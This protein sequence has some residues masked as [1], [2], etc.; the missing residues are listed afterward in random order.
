MSRI[1]IA[2][3]TFTIF[4]FLILLL[5]LISV[6]MVIKALPGL[7]NELDDFKKKID[8]VDTATEKI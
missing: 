7:K 6:I 8:K 2:N 1:A 4:N 3:L 5:F